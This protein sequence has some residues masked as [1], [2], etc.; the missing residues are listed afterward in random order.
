[1]FLGNQ[2]GRRTVVGAH[3]GDGPADILIRPGR[4][5]PV[6]PSVADRPDAGL[7]KKPLG[8]ES[9]QQQPVDGG[10]TLSGGLGHQID[11]DQQP[12]PA[13]AVDVLRGVALKNPCEIVPQP[14]GIE[15]APVGPGHGFQTVA[16]P[17]GGLEHTFEFLAARLPRRA[18]DTNVIAPAAVVEAR[19][20]LVGAGR[21]LDDEYISAGFGIPLHLQ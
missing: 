6:C 4:V 10:C 21:E 19:V 5:V 2:F 7:W 14:P 12:F 20:G 17:A 18:A 3:A 1:M 11:V 8:P 13:G 9:E 15:G 16:Q